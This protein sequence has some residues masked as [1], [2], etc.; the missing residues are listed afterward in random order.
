[1]I[2]P[3]KRARASDARSPKRRRPTDGPQLEPAPVFARRSAG[4][5]LAETGPG[6]SAP[7]LARSPIED[8]FGAETPVFVV[9][10]DDD[11]DDFA[12]TSPS[13][14]APRRAK[15]ARASP[16][17]APT[18]PKTAVAV[19]LDG[20]LTPPRPRPD[21]V[22][23]GLL[24]TPAAYMYDHRTPDRA[25]SAPA[26]LERMFAVDTTF[27]S[28]LDFVIHETPL[29]P[30][31]PSLAAIRTNAP[32]SPHKPKRRRQPLAELYDGSENKENIDPLA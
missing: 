16:E 9:Y 17:D 4:R 20:L 5:V 10:H 13:P 12:P 6:R 30:P 21:R 2:L 15:R 31:T 8:E 28:E 25:R 19:R 24:P 7:T 32:S 3:T 18:T 22:R 11:A 23:A 14:V 1:M 26:R 29:T 27:R